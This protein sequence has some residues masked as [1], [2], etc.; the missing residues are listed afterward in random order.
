[1]TNK[2]F[3]SVTLIQLHD[4]YSAWNSKG[5][6]IPDNGQMVIIEVDDA[7]VTA[8]SSTYIGITK[9]DHL[10]KI[11]DGVKTLSAL[12][13]ENII[14]KVDLPTITSEVVSNV[15]ANTFTVPTV[16]VNSKTYS[17]TVTGDAN[18]TVSSTTDTSVP[19]V[20]LTGKVSID[21]Q[22]AS[23]SAFNITPK[24]NVN[25]SKTTKT[26]SVSLPEGTVDIQT[27]DSTV[28]T[29]VDFPTLSAGS[30]TKP[31]LSGTYKGDE[32]KLTLTL[33]Q[34]S[35]TFPSLQGGT[36]NTGTALTTIGNAT[37]TFNTNATLSYESVDSAAFEGTSSTISDVKATVPSQQVDV[38]VAGRLQANFKDKVLT[39][40][41]NG[42]D[43][44][45]G[46]EDITPDLKVTKKS[47]KVIG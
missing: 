28:I 9:G 43:V 29:A 40:T 1:M 21:S 6:F 32:E 25:L 45:V 34:G 46:S 33:N 7:A 26:A 47:I 4:T 37:C 41:A 11:G 2:T 15:T 8:L 19:S 10:I 3:D 27:T 20:S 13:Y 39:G 38:T 18:L 17:T 23:V 22:K 42:I 44:T 31:S 14:K 5:S 12:P 16:S 36:K 30:Y 35:I 24:G